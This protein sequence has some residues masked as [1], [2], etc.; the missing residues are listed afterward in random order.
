MLPG[1]ARLAGHTFSCQL[2]QIGYLEGTSGREGRQVG[3]DSRDDKAVAICI[4]SSPVEREV[5]ALPSDQGIPCPGVVKDERKASLHAIM[6][7]HGRF[8]QEVL[9]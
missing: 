6:E 8:M 7:N 9:I 4:V 5:G 3:W 2:Q 1:I